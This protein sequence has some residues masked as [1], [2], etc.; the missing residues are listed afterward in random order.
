SQDEIA[1]CAC[2]AQGRQATWRAVDS[3]IEFYPRGQTTHFIDIETFNSRCGLG[4]VVLLCV[5]MAWQQC[6]RHQR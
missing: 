5:C 3:E 1:R 4:R 2:N 6:Q